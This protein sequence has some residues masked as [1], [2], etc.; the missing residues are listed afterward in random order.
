M[1]DFCTVLNGFTE[2]IFP[3]AAQRFWP[4]HCYFPYCIFSLD[5]SDRNDNN[6]SGL[7]VF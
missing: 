1:Q 7:A 2:R 4:R 3:Y 5:Y 6:K